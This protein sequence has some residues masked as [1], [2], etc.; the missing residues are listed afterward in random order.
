MLTKKDSHLKTKKAKKTRITRVTTIS[1]DP[2][3]YST[4]KS[5]NLNLSAIVKDFL[6]EYLKLNF[7]KE[8]RN[9]ILKKSI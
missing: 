9:E 6:E 2:A 1:I 8:Y 7:P 5:L 3:Q 4:V